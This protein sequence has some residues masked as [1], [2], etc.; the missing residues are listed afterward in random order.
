MKHPICAAVAALTLFGSFTLAC[1]G[2]DTTTG[3]SSGG[4]SGGGFTVAPRLTD[5]QAKVLTPSCSFTSCHGGNFPSAQLNLQPGNS[6]AELVGVAATW[7]PLCDA[8]TRNLMRVVA[9]QPDQSFLMDKLANTDSQLAARCLGRAMPQGNPGLPQ[10][11]LDAIA[12]W[13]TEG[14]QDN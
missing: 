8:G 2:L 14:A 11:A 13:I 6:Y 7:Q 9:G 12:Q 1:D 3:T 10:A 4:S 5:I